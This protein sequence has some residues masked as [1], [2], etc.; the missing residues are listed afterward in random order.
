M[1]N[2]GIIWQ[3][4]DYLDNIQIQNNQIIEQNKNMIIDDI[5]HENYPLLGRR[6]E[7][8]IVATQIV[9]LDEPLNSSNRRRDLAAIMFE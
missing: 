7:L 4:G 1:N 6:I 8:M 3:Y 2:V 5:R 9:L